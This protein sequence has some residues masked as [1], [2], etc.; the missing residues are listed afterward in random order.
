M[1]WLIKGIDPVKSQY[2]VQDFGY[3]ALRWRKRICV[4]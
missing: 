1:P 2:E 4:I 3:A